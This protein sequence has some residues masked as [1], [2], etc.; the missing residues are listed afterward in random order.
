MEVG[1]LPKA[2]PSCLLALVEGLA[3]V[4]SD[5]G[6][7]QSWTTEDLGARWLLVAGMPGGGHQLAWEPHRH[8]WSGRCGGVAAEP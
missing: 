5:G 3:G 6:R 8:H 2:A 4:V 1:S 7:V